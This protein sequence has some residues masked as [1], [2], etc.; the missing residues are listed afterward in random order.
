MWFSMV[1]P[2]SLIIIYSQYS[3]LFPQMYFGNLGITVIGLTFNVVLEALERRLMR[4]G[5]GRLR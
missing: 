5:A 4:L 2:G 1:A 3:F